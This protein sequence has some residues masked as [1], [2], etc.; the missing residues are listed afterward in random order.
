M[1]FAGYKDFKD[2]VSQNKDQDNPEAYCATVHKKSTGK[3]PTEEE[4][5]HE[6]RLNLLYERVTEKDSRPPKEWWDKMFANVKKWYGF[7][8]DVARKVVGH[9][10]WHMKPA[11]RFKK[12]TILDKG[13]V[14]AILANT[15][16]FKKM[17][18]ENKTKTG[19]Q[20]K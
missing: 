3:W 10:W 11:L 13:K 9:I 2:C 19:G 5:T 1:P 15:K 7:A 18:G 12:T 6:E 16:W 8:D 4:F 14:D 20:I 17:Y